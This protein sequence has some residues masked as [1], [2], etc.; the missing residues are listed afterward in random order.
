[1]GRIHSNVLKQQMMK[2]ILTNPSISTYCQNIKV[3]PFRETLILLLDDDINHL[4]PEEMAMYLFHMKSSSQ[5]S[6]IKTDILK[7]RTLQESEK[8]KKVKEY[9]ATPEG[10]LT[11]RQAPTASYWRQLCMNTGLCRLDG[12]LLKL[13]ENM[14]REAKQLLEIYQDEIYDFKDNLP[15]WHDYFTSL[16]N[17]QPID[18]RL[19]LTGV[20][21]IQYLVT[22]F[23]N[24][25]IIRGALLSSNQ[26]L[27]VSLFPNEEIRIDITDL[28]D[29]NV[30]ESAKKTF[31]K[32]DTS[33]EISLPSVRG[34]EV[35]K[36]FYAQKITELV[37]SSDFDLQYER[38]LKIIS[39]H[40]KQDLLSKK[41]RAWLRG[42]RLEFLFCKL[43]DLIESNGIISELHWN[44]SID[45]FGIA[46]PTPGLKKGLPDIYFKCGAS[47]YLLELTTIT[48]P[49]SQWQAEG[50]SVPFHIKNFAN[51]TGIR[52]VV[53]IF[54]A[55]A[56]DEKVDVA[57]KNT[58]IPDRYYIIC[59][60][61]NDFVDILLH[62][63]DLNKTLQKLLEEQY[64]RID[65]SNSDS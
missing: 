35:D 9:M 33:C 19:T 26:I 61:V 24:S 4:S 15:L 28:E 22:L 23:E 3:A 38:H 64:K 42:G 30:I 36:N 16:R 43:L 59:I 58:L 54:S 48:A 2:L 17:V 31:V 21:S 63:S 5:R 20:G 14:R 57:L 56:I 47:F 50:S 65:T 11:L 39:K 12:G 7:F 40:I 60:S 10:N 13:R 27:N 6:T 29:G 1:M 41:R 25:K 32:T 53:G 49:S 18:I 52:D 55:P 51:N 44:G 46:H 45:E 62:S 37:S 8:R 34:I